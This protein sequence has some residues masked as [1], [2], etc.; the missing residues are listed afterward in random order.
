MQTLIELF[1]TFKSRGPSIAFINRTGV[2][3]LIF[4]YAELSQ[5][6]LKMARLLEDKGVAPGDRVLI[7]GPN[8]PWWAVAFWGTIIRGAIAVPVDFMSERG[9]A[10]TIAG[11]TEARVIL[12]SRFKMER[13]N[14]VS[15]IFLEDLEY[16]LQEVEPF[17]DIAKPGPDD[18]AELIFTS[19]TTGNPK[20]VILTHANLMAN[21]VQVDEHIPVVGPEFNFLSL[22][23]L[24]HM[25]E[26]MG[27]FLTPLYNG[28]TIVYLRTLKPS[29]IMEA[30]GEEDIYA[31]IAVPRL[32]Q[33][34][35]TS[36]ERELDEK[37]LGNAFRFM[38]NKAETLSPALRKLVFYPV[39]RKFGSN[40]S[41]FVSGGAPLALD[42]FHFWQNLGFR[43]VEGYGLTECSPVLAANTI[44]RQVAGSVGMPL[45]GIE[46]TLEDNEILARGPNIFPGY[47]RNETATKEAFTADGR[48][49]TGDM[50]ELRPDGWLT[51]KGRAKELIVTGAGINVYPDEIEDLLNGTT[52]VR[53]SCVIG[54]DRGGGE[55]VHAV[56]LLDG[57]GRN[58]EEI[59]RQVNQRLDSLHQITG[60]TVWNEPEFPKTTTL[61]IKKFQVKDKLKKGQK[62]AGDSVGDRLTGLVARVTGADISEIREESRLVADLGLSSI[63]RLELIN[64]LEQEYRLD[65]EDSVIGPDT[66]VQDLRRIID[67]REK[68]RQ[69][70]HFR[71][72][73]NSLPIR[74][75]RMVWDAVF[76]YP[77]F[78]SM[79]TLEVRGAEKLQEIKGPVFF[80]SNHLSYIDQ[81]AVMFALPREIR[82][83]TATAAWE[84]F[85]FENYRN[86][87][88]K[89]WKRLAYEYATLLHNV[90]PL[91]QSSGFRKSFRFMGKLVD[92][93]RNI[94]I[95]PEGER[96]VDGRLLP[97]QRGL[98]IM[99]KELDIPVVPVKLVGLEK[100]LP[101][102]ATWPKRGKVTVIIGSPIYLSK[103]EPDRLVEIARSAVAKL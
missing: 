68:I 66:T 94:L 29:A 14:H 53:E 51:I 69:K 78:R 89:L 103:E 98:G 92:S 40:F 54:L 48:F 1:N 23:P 10:E 73:T 37:K 71:F 6:S 21:L 85:F 2:R 36:I 5:L 76:T 27:G 50:G 34:L 95:F 55:E 8:S 74:G 28:S 20:G 52:G 90:F 33:L 67:K 17:Q 46:I 77:L 84:E 38:M 39:Q 101:R 35:K 64:Y 82:Y 31:V 80:V 3:R 93:G 88:Q 9:R 43:V 30:F 41:L 87:A 4:S 16:L 70:N 7:W 61:K 96:S 58:P 81:S 13:L 25:F 42:T 18:I 56:L 24:S 12:E 86:F 26:Q 99:V 97:F 75:L 49:R 79:V 59:V 91:P 47:Y 65:L 102:G 11:V 45:P 19:G 32:L 22:L 15:S 72:W 62:S 100:V 44:D 63:A 60:F 83:N 57:S